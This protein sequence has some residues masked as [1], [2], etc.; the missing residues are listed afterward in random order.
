MVMEV[1]VEVIVVETLD[2]VR[3]GF[4]V[5]FRRDCLE[6]IM[7]VEVVIEVMLDVVMLV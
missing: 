7:D 6:D 4:F 3:A 1:L 2:V 5:F